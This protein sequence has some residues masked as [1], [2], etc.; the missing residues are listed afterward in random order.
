MPTVLVFPPVQAKA[1]STSTR[2]HVL[3]IKDQGNEKI[4][5]IFNKHIIETHRLTIKNP[6]GSITKFYSVWKAK[7]ESKFYDTRS[8]KII[9]V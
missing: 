5:A 4:F 8:T 1:A 9:C 6:K 3:R 2:L 7:T